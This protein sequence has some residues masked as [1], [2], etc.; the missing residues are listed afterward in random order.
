MHFNNSSIL[1]SDTKKCVGSVKMFEA[2]YELTGNSG[3]KR[4][5]LI[6]SVLKTG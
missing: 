2:I 6:L 4:A 3:S 5:G 1:F